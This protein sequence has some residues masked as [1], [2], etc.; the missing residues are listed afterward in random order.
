MRVHHKQPTLVS[1]WMLDV[2]CCALGCVTLLWL[3]N[4]RQAHEQT[5]AART[6]LS[7]LQTT[8]AD[9]DVT[10]GDRDSARAELLALRAAADALRVKLTAEVQQ[11]TGKVTDLDAARVSLAA[12]MKTLN[13]QLVAAKKEKDDTA[14]KLDAALAD[15]KAAK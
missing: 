9:L 5:V 1:M 11:L 2:F 10:R 8:Q 15:A 12:E 3:L 13:E 6:A 4:T 14:R 7:S